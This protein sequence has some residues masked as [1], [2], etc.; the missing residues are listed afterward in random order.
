MDFGIGFATNGLSALVA[1]RDL[2]K[3]AALSSVAKGNLGLQMATDAITSRGDSVVASEV[4]VLTAG[5]NPTVDLV[6]QTA[7][8]DS[9]YGVEAKLGP[10]ARLS[11]A[12]S[13]G[14]A[15]INAGGANTL[16]GSNATAAGIAGDSLDSV[17]LMHFYSGGYTPAL[18]NT[19][20][21]ALGADAAYQGTAAAMSSSGGE[22]A[23]GGYL[24]YPNAPNNNIVSVY[25][26]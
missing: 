3:I 24:I 4:R 6:A 9:L 17:E 2:S 5:G 21:L 18:S 15:E 19:L 25:Q 8:E 16:F 22:S 20:P 23:A 26:K 12:Q 13:G 7:G 1:A 14:Y 10:S 11:S